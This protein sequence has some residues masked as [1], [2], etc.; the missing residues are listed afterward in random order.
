[1]A[2]TNKNYCYGLRGS[3]RPIAVFISHEY[4]HFLAGDTL[5]STTLFKA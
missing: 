4:N 2:L 3:D 5:L 1:M